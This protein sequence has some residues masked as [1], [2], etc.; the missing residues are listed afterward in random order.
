VVKIVLKNSTLKPPEDAFL[1]AQRS[2]KTIMFNK[3][4]HAQQVVVA[5][6]L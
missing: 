4:F 1:F 2:F 3:A 5:F 6:P